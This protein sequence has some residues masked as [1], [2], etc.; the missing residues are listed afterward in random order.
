[1]VFAIF[2]KA[3]KGFLPLDDLHRTPAERNNNPTI[4]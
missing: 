4:F 1:M 3:Q 2:L